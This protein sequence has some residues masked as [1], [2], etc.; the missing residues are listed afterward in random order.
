MNQDN[1]IQR[2]TRMMTS[3]GIVRPT[4]G[5]NGGRGAGI[6]DHLTA[7]PSVAYRTPFER[8]RCG[9]QWVCRLAE[10]NALGRGLTERRRG[11]RE[12]EHMA[13]QLVDAAFSFNIGF[14]DGEIPD[15]LTTEAALLL[16][17]LAFRADEDGWVECSLATLRLDCHFHAVEIVADNL[18]VLADMGVIQWRSIEPQRV[19]IDINALRSPAYR[20]ELIAGWVDQLLK[21][22]LVG[23]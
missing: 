12:G 11:N 8:F 23:Q 9:S 1:I 16:L 13:K 14:P 10:A 15:G 3:Q 19:F 20:E 7:H 4:V 2:N 5:R 6:L 21:D 18:T 17:V 22:Y